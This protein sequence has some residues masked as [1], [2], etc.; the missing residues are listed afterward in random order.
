MLGHVWLCERTDCGPT[1]SS[2]HG[3]SQARMGCYFLLQEIFL[4]QGSSPRLL[5]LLHWRADPFPLSPWKPTLLVQDVSQYEDVK[6]SESL[7]V[8][9]DSLWPHGP[10]SP[11]NSPGQNTELASRSLLQGIFPTQGSNSGL[12]HCR[13]ILYRLSHKGNPRILEWVVWREGGKLKPNSKGDSY[14]AEFRLHSMGN[15]EASK[16]FRLC[17]KKIKG[18]QIVF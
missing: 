8:V 7:S 17:F 3:I 12:P 9:S 14:S 6:W 4:T 13:R 2:V 1:G 11:W 15:G 5:K 10:Y 16:A 18:F